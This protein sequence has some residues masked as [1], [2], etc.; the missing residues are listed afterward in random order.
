MLLNKQRQIVVEK[1]KLGIIDE[2]EFERIVQKIDLRLAKLHNKTPKE[3][4]LDAQ[5][6]L[7]L[8]KF[9]NK[10]FKDDEQEFL[11]LAKKASSD[12]NN[13]IVLYKNDFL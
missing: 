7:K 13:I 8:N 5:E 1:Q 11:L 4:Q 9:L 6:R 3:Y 2:K 12:Q 10:I